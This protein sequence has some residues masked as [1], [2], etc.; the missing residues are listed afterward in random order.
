MICAVLNLVGK[1]PC[2]KER[3][4]RLAMMTE[5]DVAH[6]FMTVEGIVS[7]G[8]DLRSVELIKLKTSAG[9]TGVNSEN[10]GPA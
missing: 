4:A 10:R 2:E 7:V 6:D 5:K 3:L 1:S 8:D 9:V